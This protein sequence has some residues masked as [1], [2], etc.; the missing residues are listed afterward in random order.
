MK[1]IIISFVALS[2]IFLVTAC[3][4]E[5]EE[6]AH[7]N[8]GNDVEEAPTD[9]AVE[10]D[11]HAHMD[12]SS[13]GEIPEGLQ[14]AE[15]PAFPVGSK[16]TIVD[17]HMS[18]MEGAEAT[19]VGAY[20]TRVYT[21]SYDPSTGGEREVNHK[22]VIHEELVDVG[23]ETLEVGAEVILDADH[24]PGMQGTLAVIDSFE[25]TTVYM[26]DFTLT[27]TGEEVQNHKWVTEDELG[28]H[29]NH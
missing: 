6:N 28:S 4:T 25:E 19:I 18:G 11:D 29:A 23:E 22:W 26:V 21:V 3:G 17:G 5:N 10:Q 1:K 15:N 8:H 9:S 16:A 27:T 14:E 2:T 7:G 24:M 13:S 12:H 20:Q